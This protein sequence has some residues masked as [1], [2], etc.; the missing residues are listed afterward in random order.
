MLS[1]SSSYLRLGKFA[2]EHVPMHLRNLINI[3]SGGNDACVLPLFFLPIYATLD[4]APYVTFFHWFL[5][6]LCFKCFG[7]VALG[8]LTGFCAKKGLILSKTYNLIDHESFLA[9]SIALCCFLSGL[10][11][12]LQVSDLLAIFSAG[13]TLSWNQHLLLSSDYSYYEEIKDSKLQ[14]VLDLIFNITFF[15]LFGSSINWPL[16]WNPPASS[17]LLVPPLPILISWSLCI[18]FLKRWPVVF[19]LKKFIPILYTSKEASFVG[20]FGPIGVGALFYSDLLSS[21]PSI[22]NSFLFDHKSM[23]EFIVFASII[24]HGITVPLFNLTLRATLSFNSNLDLVASLLPSPKS[25]NI[26]TMDI[27]SIDFFNYNDHM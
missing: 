11:N 10:A 1:A 25:T 2:E 24:L 22:T 13:I 3:E 8:I 17:P 16:Y 18:L 6:I 12:L 20:W 14:E 21:S 4:T 26:D 9:F 7:A 15:F 27:D 23:I 5:D 19:I